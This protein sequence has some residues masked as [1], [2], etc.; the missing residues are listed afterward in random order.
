M[1]TERRYSVLTE[2]IATG[3]KALA[4]TEVSFHSAQILLLYVRFYVSLRGGRMPD[5]AISRYNVG[6]AVQ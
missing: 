2:R 1:A 6:N 4:M 3:L 5:V